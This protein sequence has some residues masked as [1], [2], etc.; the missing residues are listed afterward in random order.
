[1]RGE[2]SQSAQ[3]DASE[4]QSRM[5]AGEDAGLQT[6]TFASTRELLPDARAVEEEREN[7]N[8]FLLHSL[9]L[10]GIEAESFDDSRRDLLI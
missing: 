6:G 1:M 4:L 2:V 10:V 8:S 3:S 7:V 9:E 5:R